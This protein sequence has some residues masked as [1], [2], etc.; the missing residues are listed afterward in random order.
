MMV[1]C[2]P[3]QLR[4][5]LLLIMLL[6]YHLLRSVANVQEREYHCIAER[7]LAQPGCYDG[8]ERE[9]TVDMTR[10][11]RLW[12]WC[13]RREERRDRSTEK[14]RKEKTARMRSCSSSRSPEQAKQLGS[15]P[16]WILPKAYFLCRSFPLVT[17]NTPAKKTTAMSNHPN[18]EELFFLTSVGGRPLMSTRSFASNTTKIQSTSLVCAPV[19]KNFLWRED[20]PWSPISTIRAEKVTVG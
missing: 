16:L 15:D 6:A 4:T 8:R 2:F 20:R 18:G 19:P 10:I 11:R 3:D 13:Q 17:L 14:R 1:S 5:D 7:R 12:Q 9:R